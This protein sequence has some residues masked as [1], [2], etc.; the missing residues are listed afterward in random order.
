MEDTVP[1]AAAPSQDG[2]SRAKLGER[3]LTT[4][5]A[6]GQSLAI[7]PIFSAG[8]LTGLVAGAAGF[9]TPL[10][11]LFGGIGALG[12]AYVISIFARRYAGAG[13]IYEYLTRGASPDVG[14]LSAGIYA[15]GL[16]FLGGGG[17]FIAI[18]FLT[19]GFFADEIEAFTISAAAGSYLIEAIYVFLAL[20]ALWLVWKA[21]SR[22]RV[23]QMIAVLIGLATPILAYKGSLDP[24]PTYPNNRGIIFALVSVGI[25][26]VWWA[27][28]RFRHPERIRTAAAY[29]D[30]H[31]DVPPLDESLEE[32]R[33]ETGAAS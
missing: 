24:W 14:V 4:L 9:N 13:A 15:I 3:R 5:H 19:S 12:L 25:A 31:E 1:S 20:T 22:Y 29:A 8:L 21:A 11:V 17:V 23:L 10:S 28:L 16:L 18:G 33:P 26:V 30:V 6:I 32:A 7:G 2:S 27:Y